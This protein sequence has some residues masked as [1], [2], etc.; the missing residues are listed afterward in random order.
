VLYAPPPKAPQLE[1]RNARFRAAPLLVSGTEAYVAGEYLYQDFLYDDY[2]SDTDGR[3]AGA[4]SNGAGNIEYPTTRARYGGN[5]ADLVEFRVSASSDSVAYRVTLNTRLEIDS[6]IVTIVYDTDRDVRTGVSALPRSPG[7][8][9]PG[10]DEL[11]TLWGSGGEH[12]RFNPLA[13]ATPLNVITDL[14]ANQMTV[15]VPR[16]I[17]NPTGVWR[18]TL[19]VGLYDPATGGWLRPAGTAPTETAPG[20][21]GALDA[22]PCAIFN[23]G[24]RFDEP[25]ISSD[26]PP[27]TEQSVALRN[28]TP[29]QYARDIDFGALLAGRVSSTVPASGTQIRLFPSRLNLGEGRDLST[30]PAYLGQLQPYSLYIPT[31]YTPGTPARFTLNLHSLSSFYWQYNGSRMVRQ[32]GEERGSLVAT[33]LSRGDDGWYQDEAE[34]DVFEMWN[35]VAARFTLDPDSAA[36]SGYSM[37]GYA[38]YR[39]GTLYPDLFGKAFTQVG[40]PADGIWVPPL[41]PTGGIE[42][43]SNLWLENARNLPYLNLVAAQDELV[44]IAGTR[45]QNLGA[46][47]LG[48]RGFDQLGYRFRFLVY[49]VAEH[50]TLSVLDDYPMA[51]DFLGDARVDRNPAHVTFAYVPASDNPALGLVHNHAYWVSELSLA[52]PDSAPSPAKGV[53]DVFSRAFGVGDPPSIPGITVGVG[54]LPYTEF[55]RVW[56]P[57]PIRLKENQLDVTLRNIGAARLNLARARI[58]SNANI[59]LIVDSDTNAVLYLDG[60][61]KKK[62]RV[63]E[64]GLPLAGATVERSGAMIPVSAGS[65]IYTIVL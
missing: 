5:A 65:H 35:D 3:G 10:T 30:F 54:P 39:L 16:S 36:I 19:A 59:R 57:A 47:E 20:G 58:N 18:A 53:I 31:T 40:P 8:P 11:I 46:P 62:A 32:I 45:A 21:I 43:L 25:V 6:T 23:L 29:T 56:G 64:D 1:N 38:T 17:S 42:T 44:P 48:I 15:I 24:F 34:Y 27:D 12:T 52:H 26:T 14:E 55:N 7:A 2:G 50:L 33:S 13:V 63:F 51:R 41:D 37:G 60:L 9:F 61:F 22:E 28:K 49:D 4:L